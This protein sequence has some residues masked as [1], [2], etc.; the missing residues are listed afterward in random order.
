M[1][2]GHVV[3]DGA[4]TSIHDEQ[5]GRTDVSVNPNGRAIPSRV[6]SCFQTSIE[7]WVS[8]SPPRI[9]IA[10]LAWAS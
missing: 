2:G 5:V 1:L 4:Q 9:A 7:A 8:I 10:S 3:D 6:E